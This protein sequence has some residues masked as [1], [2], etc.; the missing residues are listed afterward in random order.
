MKYITLLLI[1]IS[2]S[3]LA[4]KVVD[5]DTA[6]D[7]LLYET[8]DGTLLSVPVNL[9][10]HLSSTTILRKRNRADGLIDFTKEKKDYFGYVESE[11][12][13]GLGLRGK[14]IEE[15]I[16][17]LP[18]RE[19]VIEGVVNANNIVARKYKKRLNSFYPIS[20]SIHKTRRGK[21]KSV[22]NY[23]GIKNKSGK[24]YVNWHTAPKG[25]YFEEYFTKDDV[26][27]QAKRERTK[28]WP[29]LIVGAMGVAGGIGNAVSSGL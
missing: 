26:T 16:K 12:V 11:N 1:S 15:F 24:L 19:Q 21:I 13:V 29:F 5:F 10:G 14:N 7:R 25:A 3:A 2:I 4:Q 28:F 23:S 20:Y 17:L 27:A 22:V 8:E 6:T 18:N 9:S